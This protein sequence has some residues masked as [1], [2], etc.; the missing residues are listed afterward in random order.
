MCVE[1]VPFEFS[2]YASIYSSHMP[3]MYVHRS[4]I[5]CVLQSPRTLLYI[6][7]LFLTTYICLCVCHLYLW[8]Y[9]LH[10][11]LFMCHTYHWLIIID[12]FSFNDLKHACWLRGS[13]IDPWADWGPKRLDCYSWPNM[14]RMTPPIGSWPSLLD[15]RAQV[16]LPY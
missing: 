2:S 4:I 6:C 7:V 16:P 15:A 12:R 11:Y 14:N 3:S 13:W 9:A 10:K 1:L 8:I 5:W